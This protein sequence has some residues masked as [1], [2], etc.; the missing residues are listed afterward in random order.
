[1]SGRRWLLIPAVVI[2]ISARAGWEAEADKDKRALQGHWL[3][4]MTE[5]DGDREWLPSD[6]VHD[7]RLEV[8][9]D[10]MV[11]RWHDEQVVACYELDASKKPFRWIDLNGRDSHGAPFVLKGIYQLQ[12][13]EF[14]VCLT[15]TSYKEYGPRYA[16]GRPT[17]LQTFTNSA[18]MLAVLKRDSS[19]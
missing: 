15:L 4:A 19:R 3:V 6:M 7:A 17:R 5:I 2:S 11:L 12:G 1:M 18:S 13:G 14:R 8:R 16:R 9:G 10:S